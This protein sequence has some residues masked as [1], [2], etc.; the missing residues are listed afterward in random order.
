M[1]NDSTDGSTEIGWGEE[2]EVLSTESFEDED[3]DVSS[4]Y[5]TLR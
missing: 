3:E 2:E 1:N 5:T 4:D